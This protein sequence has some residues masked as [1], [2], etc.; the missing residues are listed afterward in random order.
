ML[1][2]KYAFVSYSGALISESTISLCRL[3]SL[4]C[5]KLTLGALSVVLIVLPQLRL[6]GF[7]VVASNY[8]IEI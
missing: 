5:C 7:I 1:V 6:A 2:F 8:P 4:Y 3:L